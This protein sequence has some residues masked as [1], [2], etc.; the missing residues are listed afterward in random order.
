MRS[1]TLPVL[2]FV[3]SRSRD[4]TVWMRVPAAQTSA[5][6]LR[7]RSPAMRPE[8]IALSYEKPSAAEVATRARRFYEFMNRR[9][10]VRDFSSEHIPAAVIEDLVRAASTAPSGAHRQPWTFVAT[11]DPEVKRQIR[12]AAEKE[13]QENYGGRLPPDWLKA[14]EPL[15]TEQHKPFLEIAPWLVVLFKQNHGFGSSSGEHIRHYYVTESVGIAAGMFLAA[16]HSAGL[17]ALTHTPS[18]MGFLKTIL[19]RPAHET[20]CLLIPVGYPATDAEVP[21][22]RRKP[23]KEVLVMR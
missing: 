4:E 15:G 17:V 6:E 1:A 18:P 12:T 7:V 19:K 21:D 23:L 20:P 22:L 11:S 2:L 8:F 3:R 9:R 5:V 14:L 10:T 16:V 13:E